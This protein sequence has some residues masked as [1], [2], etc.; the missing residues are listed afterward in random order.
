MKIIESSLTGES[1]PTE[2]NASLVFSNP[3]GIGDRLNLA[4]M[5]TTVSY[6][7]GLGVVVNT[8]ME[9]E[10]GK[11]ATSIDMEEENET[12]LQ[13]VLAKLSKYLG[14]LT[15]LIVILVLVVDFIWIL[16]MVRI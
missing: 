5:S 7:R 12:P 2:K 1:V 11:I 15:L 13:K 4:Y 16:L 6:G 10:I 14:L 8:G 3:V 9:T